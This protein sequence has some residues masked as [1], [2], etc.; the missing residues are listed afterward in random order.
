MSVGRVSESPASDVAAADET[1][2]V[3]DEAVAVSPPAQSVFFFASNSDVPAA[4][5]DAALLQHAQYLKQHPNMILV[6]S[7][8]ADSRGAKLYNQHLS[9]QRAQHVADI[10]LA[11]GVSP[12]QLRVG[13]MGDSVPMINPKHWQE[14]RRVEFVY[15]DSMVA[16]NQ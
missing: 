14:N 1:T 16:N 13:G 12:A 9:E 10:L 4:G 11:A 3:M 7:G 8:H 15:Q 2:P 6:I 5:D